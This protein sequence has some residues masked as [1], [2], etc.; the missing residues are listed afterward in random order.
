MK[1]INGFLALRVKVDMVLAPCSTRGRPLGR[2]SKRITLPAVL[3]VYGFCLREL[4][5]K[6]L[7]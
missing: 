4:S 2:L 7:N 6:N 5:N 3:Q 1:E